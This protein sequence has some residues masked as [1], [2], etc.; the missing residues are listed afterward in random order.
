LANNF[1]VLLAAEGEQKILLE[2][3]FPALTVLPLKGYRVSYSKKRAFL[4][5]KILWQIPKILAAIKHEQVWLQQVIEEHQIDLVISDNRYGLHHQ[6]VPC[7]FI[8]HQLTIKTPFAWLEKLLQR[9]NYKYINRFAACWVPDVAGEMNV[10][11]ILSHPKI[12]PKIPIHYV[13]LLSRFQVETNHLPI[14]FETTVI[15]SGPEPQRTL[16]EKSII[17]SAT[18]WQSGLLLVRGKPASTENIN[19]PNLVVKNH[20]SGNELAKEIAQSHFIVC[21]SGYTS[22][23]ELLTLQKK[24]ILIPTP[25]QTEQEYLAARL[26]QQ[27]WCYAVTQNEFDIATALQAA[28]Q[29]TYT[30]PA[31]ENKYLGVLIPQ[32]IQALQQ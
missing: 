15:L 23:M 5:V 24:T 6:Q 1:K 22:L 28:Q 16:L 26:M 12:K 20:L 3:E 32:L 31:V 2:K 10:A 8:T 7:V 11:G 21:R 27:G 14:K 17:A 9:I 4:P 29:F 18:N 13:G 25:G 19:L 30:L